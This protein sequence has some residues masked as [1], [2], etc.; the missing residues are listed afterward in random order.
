MRSGELTP[1]DVPT[2][3]DAAIRALCRARE[4]AIADRKVVALARAL[5]GLMWAMAQQVPVPP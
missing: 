2:V 3:D 4:E 1:V 5:V